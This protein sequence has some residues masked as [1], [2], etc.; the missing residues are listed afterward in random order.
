VVR[1]YVEMQ[2]RLAYIVATLRP[3]YVVEAGCGLAI[4][5]LLLRWMYIPGEAF[6]ID[7]SLIAEANQLAGRLAIDL[8]CRLQDFNDW[9]P[10]V[11]EDT[12]LLADKPAGVGERGELEAAMVSAVFRYGF[13]FAIVTAPRNGMTEHTMKLFCEEYMAPLHDSGYIVQTIGLVEHIPMR[14]VLAMR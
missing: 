8:D 2:V 10:N 5:S 9:Q 13:N 11:P 14:V 7:E 12:L 6:D 4:P 1:D 3:S